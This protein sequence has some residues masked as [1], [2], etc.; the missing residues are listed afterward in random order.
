[1]PREYEYKIKTILGRLD[2]HHL[3]QSI[4]TLSGG[5][6]KR[7]ALAKLL[8]EDPELYI[9]DEPTN[10]RTLIRLSGWRNY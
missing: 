9:L 7:L 10:H 3:N 4:T 6:K 5:Q 8:I 1:M 2:I